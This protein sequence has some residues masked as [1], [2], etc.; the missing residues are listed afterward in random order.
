M[1]NIPVYNWIAMTV[2]SLC[3]CFFRTMTD[4]IDQVTD[5]FAPDLKRPKERSDDILTRATLSL[6][7]GALWFVFVPA[8]LY[9]GLTGSK[10]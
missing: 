6:F 4:A 5:R 10:K 2:A 1:D 8:V 7:V 3:F 9:V